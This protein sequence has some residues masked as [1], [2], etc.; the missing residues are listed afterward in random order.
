M[1]TIDETETVEPVQEITV[2][3]YVNQK[4]AELLVK[5]D[6]VN[7][8]LYTVL[9]QHA[10][11]LSAQNTLVNFLIKTILANGLTVDMTELSQVMG[12]PVEEVVA[13]ESDVQQETE[14]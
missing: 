3:Q 2:E 4:F 1:T 11:T 8:Q 9:K 5:Q 12:Q 10:A 7:E 14:E 13:E 6:L